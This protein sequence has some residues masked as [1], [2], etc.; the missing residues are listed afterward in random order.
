M[1][2]KNFC[3]I[4]LCISMGVMCWISTAFGAEMEWNLEKKLDLKSPIIDMA[5]SQDGQKTFLLDQD[6]NLSV[7]KIDGEIE[8]TISVGK[9]FDH[10]ILTPE[11]N[12]LLLSNS[13]KKTLE[14]LT[15]DF[16][17]DINIKGSPFKGPEDAPVTLILFTDFQ[18]PYC[19]QVGPE[20]E[21]ILKEFPKEVK[22]V[23]KS[24]PLRSHRYAVDAAKAALAAHKLG[25]FWEFHDLL[26]EN[27]NKLSPDKIKE[28]RTQLKLDEKKFNQ[29]VNAPET[30]DMIRTD[31]KD[32]I[33]SGVRGTPSLYLNGKQVKDRKPE[34]LKE[35]IKA[36]LKK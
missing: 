14:S 33:D 21:S 26:F 23:Y 19:A 3:N 9:G 28:I 7:Y 15:I 22:L 18:C 34:A 20:L 12:T 5:L 17:Y 4:L 1:T 11:P 6:G 16:I 36:E 2:F 29:Y 27:Y 32:G 10:I 13:E 24:F 25:K 8:T 30:M 31:Y 35:A